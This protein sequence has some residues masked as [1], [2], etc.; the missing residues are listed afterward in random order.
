MPPEIPEGD[1]NRLI[2]IVWAAQDGLDFVRGRGR[3]ALGTD[4][5]LL[6]ATIHSVQEIGEAAGKVSP[7]TRALAPALPWNQIVGMRHRLVHAYFN[8]NADYL[9]QVLTQDL[10]VLVETLTAV[11]GTV[12]SRDAAEGAAGIEG[13]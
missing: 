9:W 13:E 11:L 5:M 7:A 6:R 2:H 1:R 8:V 3:D 10:P 12:P 4:R